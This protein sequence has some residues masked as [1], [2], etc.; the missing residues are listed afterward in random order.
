MKVK[1]IKSLFFVFF[2]FGHF[3]GF[4]VDNTAKP[5]KTI[6]EGKINLDTEYVVYVSD[7][8]DRQTGE[9]FPIAQNGTFKV[10]LEI[11]EPTWIELTFGS[12]AKDRQLGASFPL[13][14]Q[15]GAKYDYTLSY[16]PETYLNLVSSRKNDDNAALIEYAGFSNRT[17]RNL[18]INPGDEDQQLETIASYLTETNKI[19]KEH[20]IKQKEIIDYLRLWSMNNYLTAYSKEKPIPSNISDQIPSVF[21]TEMT[22]SFYNG[23]T[24]V[25]DFVTRLIAKEDDSIK[26]M[27]NRVDKLNELFANKELIVA[28]VGGS[29]QRYV[30]GYRITSKD[31]FSNDAKRLEGLI[32][33]IGVDEFKM[34]LL[35]DFKNLHFTTIGSPI[36]DVDFKDVD[37]KLV[38][39]DQFKGDYIY[40]DLWASWCVPCIKEIPYLQQLEKDF[41]DKNVTFISLSLDDDKNA[42]KKKVKELNLQGNQW[43][44]GQS[45]LDKLMNVKGIPHF[46]LYGP[47]GK[48]LMYNAPR[49]SSP[50]VRE[51]F[52]NI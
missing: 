22:L 44:V 24:N 7:L 16:S 21:D 2:I 31:S 18:F 52:E 49:P 39:L 40:I 4:A 46:I 10:E 41:A 34:S 12:I 47:D 23:A 13:F 37:G 35:K 45:E 8:L 19:I 38:R 51:I 26:M 28:V 11:D 29:L 43:E 36:P 27:G 1:W 32:D 6:I 20:K 50:Q 33:K 3:L 30:S 14:L 42:W 48:L 15:A 25:N 5:K 17:I 9:E